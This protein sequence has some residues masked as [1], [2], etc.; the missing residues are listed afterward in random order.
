[1]TP[2]RAEQYAEDAPERYRCR[3]CQGQLRSLEFDGEHAPGTCYEPRVDH[4]RQRLAWRKL[5]EATALLLIRAGFP[6]EAAWHAAEAE[7]GR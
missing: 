1:M 3:R 5:H 6:E 4:A 7:R 2:E